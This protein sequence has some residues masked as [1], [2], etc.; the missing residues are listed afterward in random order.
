MSR[1]WLVLI[2]GVAAMEHVS[3]RCSQGYKHHWAAC[4]TCESYPYRHPHF[5]CLSC[6]ADAMH[7]ITNTAYKTGPC[8]KKHVPTAP[9][10]WSQAN[11][12]PK[13]F[14]YCCPT[15]VA[16]NEVQTICHKMLLSSLQTL[17]WPMSK[18][19]SHNYGYASCLRL[20]VSPIVHSSALA[21]YR[22]V[23]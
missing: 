15:D 22:P 23:S 20:K 3:A 17:S 1:V 9:V 12:D 5:M 11:I 4:K 21:F 16:A 8:K 14:A 13:V 10:S 19:G 2:A 7:I 18:K 6:H